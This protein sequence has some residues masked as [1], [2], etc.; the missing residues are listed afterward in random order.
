MINRQNYLD[1]KQFMAYHRKALQN[2]ESTINTYE[3]QIRHALIWCDSLPFS[4]F[5]KAKQTFPE[6]LKE[7]ISAGTLTEQG[8]ADICLLF[9]EFLQ[10][11]IRENQDRYSGIKESQVNEIKI[12]T[13]E[14]STLIPGYYS[15]DE[16]KQIAGTKV[17]TLGLQRV[18]AG[19]C[20]LFLSGMRISAMLSISSE[21]LDLNK[22]AVYQFPDKGVVTKFSKKAVTT[23]LNIPFLLDVVSEWN[24]LLR[25]N[26]IPE[27]ALWYS[28]INKPGTLPIADYP[29][30]NNHDAAYK[31][32]RHDGTKF[33][34]QLKNLCLLADVEYKNPHAFRHGHIH[35]GLSHAKSIEQ[36]KAISQNVMHGSTAIT[37]KIYSRMNHEEV[38]S[39]IAGLGVEESQQQLLYENSSVSAL[40]A[41]LSLDEKKALLK[42]LLGL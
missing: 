33:R 12:I 39:V 9:R 2:S 27:S 28:R 6:Y 16:M 30:R 22:K 21:C 31:K 32:A 11:N 35:Y 24:E 23:L 3:R 25:E 18:K 37:D 20:L 8:A 29:I 40:I 34:E 19:A 13:H 10:F 41:T 4:K 26:N 14:D 7:F 36:A 38:S 17:S 15:L 5:F 1:V 42:E